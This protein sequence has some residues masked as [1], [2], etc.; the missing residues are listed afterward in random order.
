MRALSS[1]LPTA[2]PMRS[3]VAPDPARL[4]VQVERDVLGAAVGALHRHGVPDEQVEAERLGCRRLLVAAGQ[5][6]QVADEVGQLLQLHQDVVDQ[7]GA[8]LD[9][10]L[11]D[12]PDHLE[13]GAQAGERGAQL[14]RRVEHELAL[15]PAR[16]LERLEQAVEGAAQPPELVGASGREPARDVGRLGQ[17]LDGVGQRVQRDQRGAG[18]QPAQ[19]DGQEDADQGHDAEQDRPSRPSSELA[20]SRVAIC[21][22]PPS[23]RMPDSNA[24]VGR[25]VLDQFAHLVAV[26]RDRREVRRSEARRPPG[27]PGRSRGGRRRRRRR[28]REWSTC[29]SVAVVEPISCPATIRCAAVVSELSV[30]WSSV[31]RATRKEAG[32]AA[33]TATTTAA[34]VASTR[35]ARKVTRPAARSPRR[36]PSG[37]SVARHPPPACAGGT[38]RRR[39]ASSSPSRS[40]SPRP[41]AAA[42]RG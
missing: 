42:P 23:R 35:R 27:A 38:R 11:V 3:A 1:R 15:G 41:G 26:D 30:A 17:V 21:S 7:H 2:R 6:G 32:E 36:A 25:Q 33:S 8:V 9:A 4:G 19:H 28:R 34:V 10:Q 40:R 22:A 24:R 16:R 31:L 5:L 37:C 39:R 13:V 18:D 20:L 29:P 14:V 12:P